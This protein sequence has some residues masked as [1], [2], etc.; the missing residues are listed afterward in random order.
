MIFRMANT[1]HTTP[2]HHTRAIQ[3]GKGG[4]DK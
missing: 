4:R 2:N 3:S 1:R